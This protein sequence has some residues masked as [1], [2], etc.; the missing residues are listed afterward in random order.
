M[1]VASHPPSPLIREGRSNPPASSLEAVAL[2]HDFFADV[3]VC[4][5]THATEGPHW[6]AFLSSFADALHA[7]N[8][9]L[10]VD[11]AG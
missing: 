11:I 4:T 7:V 9:T 3:C 10:S 6:M 2:C 8:K 5:M 1:G